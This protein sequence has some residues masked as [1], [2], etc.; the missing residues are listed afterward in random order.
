[1]GDNFLVMKR[2]NTLLWSRT[3]EILC[4]HHKEILVFINTCF[5]KLLKIR[6]PD[7]I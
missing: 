1:M 2:P 5:R 6:W 4:H 3:L 7:K